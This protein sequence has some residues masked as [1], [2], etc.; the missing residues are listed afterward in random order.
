MQK[1]WCFALTLMAC[2]SSEMATTDA[3][4]VTP[5]A[6]PADPDAGILAT[7]LAIDLAAKH[8]TATIQLSGPTSLEV[9]G[10]TIQNVTAPGPTMMSG[11]GKQLMVDVQ[12]GV[13]STVVVDYTYKDYTGFMGSMTGGTTLIWPYYCGNLFPCHSQPADGLR[14]TMTL[15]NPPAGQIAVYPSVI[16]AD[17]PSYQ[18]AWAVGSYVHVDLGATTNGTHVGFWAI[19]GHESTAMTGTAHMRDVFDWYEQTYGAY[20]FGPEVASVEVRWPAGAYGGMEHHP[21]WHISQAAMGDH[22]VHAHEASHGW[23]GD[24]IRIRCWEDFVLSE[25]TADYLMLRSVEQTE[26]ATVG[27]QA[28]TDEM[29]KL[30]NAVNS[31]DHIA[32]PDSCGVLDILRDNLFTEIPY[33]KGAFFYKAV[34]NQIGKA[35]LDHA[36]KRFYAEHHNGTAGMQDMLDTIKADSG[37]D[38]TALAQSWLRSMGIPQ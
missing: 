26:G 6:T 19:S 2:G 25:G 12:N 24:G 33:T 20:T 30:Q 9:E 21:Y 15:T 8:G 34:E 35:A 13:V 22:L 36:F 17:A 16:P 31:G 1:T 28:W 23:F 37:F 3:A 7:D 38:P 5:D 11:D 10:L 32:W 4:S 27:Q 29:T 18:I 14:F